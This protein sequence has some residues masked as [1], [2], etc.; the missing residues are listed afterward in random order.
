MLSANSSSVLVL[1]GTVFSARVLWRRLL[2]GLGTTVSGA[3]DV[4]LDAPR[5]ASLSA[6]SV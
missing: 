1:V 3:K 5:F 6:I 4:I 2:V